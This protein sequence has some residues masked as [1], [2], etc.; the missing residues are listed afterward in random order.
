MLSTNAAL[1]EKKRKE[2]KGRRTQEI[3]RIAL[4]SAKEEGE[5]GGR[6]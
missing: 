4:I 3:I 2:R 6:E 1:K 5:K